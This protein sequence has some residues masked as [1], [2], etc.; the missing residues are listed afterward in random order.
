MKSKIW[1]MMKE[2]FFAFIFCYFILKIEIVGGGL[3]AGTCFALIIS[4]FTNFITSIVFGLIILFLPLPIYVVASLIGVM[5][6]SSIVMKSFKKQTNQIIGMILSGLM[7]FAIGYFSKMEITFSIMNMLLAMLIKIIMG[8]ALSGIKEFFSMRE[9]DRLQEIS[10]FTSIFMVTVGVSSTQL[11]YGNIYFLIIPFVIISIEMIFNSRIS[12]GVALAMAI[13]GYVGTKSSVFMLLPI[14]TVF[15]AFALAEKKIYLCSL[16]MLFVGV[17]YY[18]LAEN[19]L[20][21]TDYIYY[22]VSI[23][24]PI[25]FPKEFYEFYNSFAK[26]SVVSLNH[27]I[28]EKGRFNSS[29]KLKELANVYR[30]IEAVY[31]NL[32]CGKIMSTNSTNIIKKEITRKQCENCLAKRKCFIENKQ[33]INE[34]IENL[35]AVAESRG[36]A[37]ILNVSEFM[38]TNCIHINEILDEINKAT[39]E[40]ECYNDNISKVDAIKLMLSKQFKGVA[41]S[42]EKLAHEMGEKVNYDKEMEYLIGEALKVNN[43]KYDEIYYYYRD[44]EKPSISIM[45]NTKKK[46]KTI[47]RVISSV[48]KVRMVV[49]S[50]EKI[51][52][53]RKNI[54]K[55]SR[56]PKYDIAFGIAVSKKADSKM[57]G[58]TNTEL[59]I[60]RDMIMFSLSDGMGSGEKA[61]EVSERA[62]SLIEN[63]YKAGFDEDVVTSTVNNLLQTANFEVFTAVDICAID[64]VTLTCNLI[65]VGSPVSFL[66]SK[67][68]IKAFE[69]ESLPM[70]IIEEIVPT[71]NRI[72]LNEG[73]YM[74]LVTDGISD[75]LKSS[76]PRLIKETISTNPQYIADKILAKAKSI[77]EGEY[78]DDMSVLVAKIVAV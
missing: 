25:V 48:S 43:I 66:K 26:E 18:F 30:E 22:A 29:Q 31:S 19:S 21:L 78:Y 49:T 44:K 64:L 57:S 33:R 36:S 45:T 17:C 16:F 46:M 61:R 56:A 76:L 10:I 55:L 24:L 11:L 67:F 74:I 2:F 12:F 32:V 9:I 20:Q 58:D 69:S 8:E 72:I 60:G 50:N 15:A 39:T 28:I 47:E 38:A 75:Q 62:I 41:T 70:G 34:E 54:I 77:G 4:G 7:G 52:G 42:L 65:K 71:K 3:V 68:E 40:I 59:R 23:L 27:N 6:L 35:I 63:L 5:A 37:T 53:K 14:I 73:D 1:K 51:E 13:G